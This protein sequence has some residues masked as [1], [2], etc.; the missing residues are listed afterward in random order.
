MNL[1]SSVMIA[2]DGF[3]GGMFEEWGLSF[4]VALV[5]GDGGASLSSHLSLIN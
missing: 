3:D 5:A 1:C 2:G 4:A